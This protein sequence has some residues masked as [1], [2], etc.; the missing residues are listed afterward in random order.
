MEILLLLLE[1]HSDLVSRAQIAARIWGDGVFVDT[2]NNINGA[3][4]KIRQVL[5]DDPEKPRFILTV[6][7]KGYRFVAPLQRDEA[8]APAIAP[9]TTA[10]LS[11]PVVVGDPATVVAD[12]RVPKRI[13]V[14][15]AA[16]LLLGLLAWAAWRGFARPRPGPV[17][18]TPITSLAVL[19]LE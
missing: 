18:A 1:H 8:S 3:I 10:D 11:Q 12:Q 9:E 4:R 5:K 13:A 15:L 7:G 16:G 17:G 6:T 19:P 14:A 2:D